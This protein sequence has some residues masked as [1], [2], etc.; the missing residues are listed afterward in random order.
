MA[1][2]G[3]DE[4]VKLCVCMK[5]YVRN[6]CVR[7]D[8]MNS[9]SEQEH[10]HTHREG[11]YSC[12][13]IMRRD[14]RAWKGRSEIKKSTIANAIKNNKNKH[15]ES[16]RENAFPLLSHSHHAIMNSSPRVLEVE[17]EEKGGR[18]RLHE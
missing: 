8:G 11:I 10:A 9:S 5:C 3:V 15:R 12:R 13:K 7:T 2:V 18:R 1:C 14:V 17:R 4:A 6:E 16:V